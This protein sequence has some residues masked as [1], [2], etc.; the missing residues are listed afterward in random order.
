MLFLLRKRCSAN[1]S[2]IIFKTYELQN[3]NLFRERPGFISRLTFK[4][5]LVRALDKLYLFN[6][7]T[8]FIQNTLK[9]ETLGTK[10]VRKNGFQLKN[11]YFCFKD[12][13]DCYA[14]CNK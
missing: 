8:F 10:E 14:E 3:N 6:I 5:N 9:C 11:S 12:K 13:Y 1:T 4:N 2:K 7:I